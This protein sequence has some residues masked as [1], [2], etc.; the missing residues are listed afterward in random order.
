MCII[1]MSIK[2]EYVRKIFS[3]EK[4]YEFRRFCAT[5]KPDKIVVYETAPASRVCGELLVGEI[6]SDAPEKLWQRTKQGAGIDYRKF[7]EYFH[8]K[9]VAYAYTIKSVKKYRKKKSLLS[10]GLRM[11]PQSFVYIEG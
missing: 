5:Q 2:G 4:K 1:M 7:M 9:E 8:G 3:G 11:A 6:I 10:Y